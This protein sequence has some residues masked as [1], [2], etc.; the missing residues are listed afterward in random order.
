MALPETHIE[1]TSELQLAEVLNALSDVKA[2]D[3]VEIDLR[4]KSTIG[5]YMI[6]ASGKSTRKVNAIAKNLTDHLK[7]TLNYP[8]RIEGKDSDDWIVV[9]TGD[10]IVHIFRPEAREFYQLDKMW[11]APLTNTTKP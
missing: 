11:R 1:L 9:D 8:S 4:G 10:I 2:E 6:I 3:V 7:R 5:D